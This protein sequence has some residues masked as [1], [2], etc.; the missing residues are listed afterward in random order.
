MSKRFLNHS[1][2]SAV[3]SL[4]MRGGFYFFFCSSPTLRQAEVLALVLRLEAVP[5]AAAAAIPEARAF[6]L[7]GVEEPHHGVVL[8]AALVL[9]EEAVIWM[10]TTQRERREFKHFQTFDEAFTDS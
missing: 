10:E 5:V 7:L 6:V 1:D 8:A 2:A 4:K 3:F 9:A